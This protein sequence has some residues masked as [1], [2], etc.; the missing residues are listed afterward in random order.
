MSSYKKYRVIKKVKESNWVVSLYLKPLDNTVLTPFKPG[1]H[2]LFKF[3][4]PGQEIPLFRHYSFSDAC[5]PEYYRLSVKKE[6]PPAGMPHLPAGM[7]SS[8]LFDTVKEGDVL[9]ARGPLGDFTLETGE[10]TPAVLIA[11]GIGITPILSM[12]KS[13]ARENP[14]RRVWFFYGV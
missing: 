14:G 10:D 3:H 1:Q 2:L 6:M 13:V 11:G 8:W 4:L 9:E 5:N 12:L 7:C